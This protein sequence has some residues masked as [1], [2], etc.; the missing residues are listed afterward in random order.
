MAV[1]DV[2][3]IK[4][5][6]DL[7]RSGSIEIT[8]LDKNKIH[9]ILKSDHSKKNVTFDIHS[10][11]SCEFLATI[12]QLL[13]LKNNKKKKKKYEKLLDVSGHDRIPFDLANLVLFDGKSKEIL[14]Q[15]H[16]N[17]ELYALLLS[18]TVLVEKQRGNPC[19]YADHIL[20]L[21]GPYHF[22]VA[23]E[24][25]EALTRRIK[26]AMDEK[27]KIISRPPHP[28]LLGVYEITSSRK[29]V[30]PYEVMLMGSK[31]IDGSCSCP[32]FRKNSLGFCKHLAYIYLYFSSHPRLQKKFLKGT[33]KLDPIFRFIPPLQYEQEINPLK[34]VFFSGNSERISA[35]NLKKI[36]DHFSWN[37]SSSL[38]PLKWGMSRPCSLDKLMELKKF[39]ENCQ[40][41]NSIQVDPA[42]RYIIGQKLREL[43]QEKILGNHMKGFQKIISS[44][45]IK[46]FPYQKKGVLAALAK[47][48]FLLADD[49]GLGKTIQGISWGNALLKSKL[50]KRLMIVCPASLKH[51]WQREWHKTTGDNPAI[52]D[53]HPEEREKIYNSK[54][55]VFILNYELI[56]RDLHLIKKIDLE[57]IILDEAQRIKNFETQT[58]RNIKQLSP[59]FRLILTGTPFENRI[60]ELMSLMDWINQQA[61]GPSWRLMPEISYHTTD[62]EG[63][64]VGGIRNLDVIRRRIAPF[65]L[66]RTRDKI[67]DQLPKR[68]DSPVVLPITDSQLE[69]HEYLKAEIAKLMR[70]LEQRPFKPEEH[71]RLMTLLTRMRIVSNGMALYDFNEIWPSLEN[72]SPIKRLNGIDSPKLGEFRNI[73]SSLL[74]QNNV[75]IVIF[76][77]WTRMLSLA[78]WSIGDMLDGDTEAVFF[79][80]NQKR[81]KRVENIVRFHDDPNVKLFFATDAGGVGLNLQ[82]AANIC[83]NLDLAWNPAVMEQRVARIHRLGQTRPVQ[84]YNLITENSIESR[85][86]DLIEQKKLVF[87]GLFDGTTNE[88]VFDKSKSFFSQVKKAVG[89]GKKTLDELEKMESDEVDDNEN[90]DSNVVYLADKIGKKEDVDNMEDVSDLSKRK[91]S[92]PSFDPTG[93]FSGIHMEKSDDGELLI[94]AK[95]DSAK[96]LAG[97]FKGFGTLL[98]NAASSNPS[99]MANQI[100]KA[101]NNPLH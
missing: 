83:I 65:F 91:L 85:I 13:Y 47:G 6:V 18:K 14:L 80:G 10:D 43:K 19:D 51:Q 74:K 78:Y 12:L 92:N 98:E 27:L 35:W 32:D 15:S 1:L 93:L 66:R 63:K 82:K 86:F 73:V 100:E 39:M 90:L 55:K 89:I 29:G 60:T 95:G 76:S 31:G 75:K 7:Y 25:M 72:D 22:H 2:S 68:V 56:R 4:K 87:N 49:M 99:N 38:H 67:L 41:R 79:T 96:V 5:A 26:S 45:K 94:K 20:K 8:S 48:C 101:E 9:I 42:L 97:L 16:K 88:I 77:Q 24:A 84:I 33:E 11:S 17:L 64:S 50:A 59:P 58:A 23:C 54:A 81:K 37:V 40:K 34:G 28:Q 46:L 30:R 21:Y 3:L 53:G 61:L 57:A 44:Q 71:L 52:V 69:V 62:G 36:K 70:I